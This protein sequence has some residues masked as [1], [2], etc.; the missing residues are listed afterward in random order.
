MSEL[1]ILISE[2]TPLCQLVK[3]QEYWSKK[4]ENVNILK[5]EV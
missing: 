1:N 5:A 3:I 4:F 2:N